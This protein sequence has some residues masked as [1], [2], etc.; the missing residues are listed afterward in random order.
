M[1]KTILFKAQKASMVSVCGKFFMLIWAHAPNLANNFKTTT[2]LDMKFK[3]CV[4]AV[5]YLQHRLVD[6]NN[7]VLE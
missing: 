2:H 6:L 4:S 3:T 7:F 5:N 1:F